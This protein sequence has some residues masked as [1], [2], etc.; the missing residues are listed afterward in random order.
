MAQLPAAGLLPRACFQATLL[1]LLLLLPD[2]LLQLGKDGCPAATGT[3]L[4]AQHLQEQRGVSFTFLH[5]GP[6]SIVLCL[7]VAAAWH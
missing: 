7:P 2:H 3:A 1:L 6:D 5:T 4:M